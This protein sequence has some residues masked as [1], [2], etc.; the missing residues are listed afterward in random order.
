[1]SETQASEKGAG[2]KEQVLRDLAAERA[3]RK[4]AETRVTQLE[5]DLA[6]ANETFDKRMEE[7]NSKLAAADQSAQDAALKAER[8]EV[9][10]S[11]NV[12][13]ELDDFITG[14]SV[15][16]VVASADK[17]MSV[18]QAKQKGEDLAEK[19]LG[20]RPD[21]TQGAT[22]VALNSDA[23]EDGLRVALNL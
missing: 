2:S 16:E 1:M 5:T 21:G 6:S 4:Q 17:A 18:F 14:S 7:L 23:L 11:K 10:R 12:P 22:D 19:P 20:M 8:L 9:L 13:A 15:E 3:R